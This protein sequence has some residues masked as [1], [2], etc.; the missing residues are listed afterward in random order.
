MPSEAVD[1]QQSINNNTFETEQKN[2]NSYEMPK[3]AVDN[4]EF[5]NNNTFLTEQKKKN[6]CEM[7][8]VAVDIQESKNDNT[9]LTEQKTESL[10]EM[11]KVINYPIIIILS[12]SFLKHFL[13]NCQYLIN[14]FCRVSK[15]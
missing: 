9:F 15:F 2:E 10:C 12:T 11:P 14:K 7:P 8:K 4:Q 1:N 5:K 3:V 6:S 13:L